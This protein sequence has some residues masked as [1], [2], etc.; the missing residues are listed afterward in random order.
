MFYILWVNYDLVW[1]DGVKIKTTKN[2][3]IPGIAPVNG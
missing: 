2:Y 3:Y 1:I